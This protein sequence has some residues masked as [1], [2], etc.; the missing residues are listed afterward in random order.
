MLSNVLLRRNETIDNDTT[1]FLQ[2]NNDV[3]DEIGS[4]KSLIAFLHS[5]KRRDQF[6]F[7]AN[8][9][10]SITIVTALFDI[11]RGDW[12]EYRRPYE[13]YLQYFEILLRL[14]NNIIIYIEE[15]SREWVMQRRNDNQTLIITMTIDQLPLWQHRDRMKSIIDSEQSEWNAEWD[16]GMR[17]HPEAKSADYNLIVN[18]KSFFIYDASRRNPFNSTHFVWLDA[19]YGHGHD[20]MYPRKWRWSPQ[21]PEHAVALIKLTPDWDQ[22]ERYGIKQL[23]RQDVSVIGGGF[24]SI[25]IALIEQFYRL[26]SSILID[27]IVRQRMID[28]DQTILV[29][30][31]QR[32]PSLFHIEHGD[33]FGAF[34]MFPSV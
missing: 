6:Q 16:V 28:D 20:D 14:N 22:I 1:P 24:Q 17:T 33:W 11:G 23:Y 25:P 30:S 5:S 10:S 2:T 29:L 3:V 19:G 4:V 12:W 7:S 27:M 34:T 32:Q 26:Y 31:V 21:L 13:Q 15:K 8:Q 9:S 18:S